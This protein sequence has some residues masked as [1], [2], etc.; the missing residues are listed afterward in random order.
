MVIADKQVEHG[1][2]HSPGHGLDDLIGRWW[3]ASITDGD[4]VEGLEIMDQVQR[5]TLLFDAEPARSVGGIGMLIYSCSKL[6]FEDLYD[7]T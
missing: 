6:V 5:A 1:V 4:G 3:N 7:V 2:A